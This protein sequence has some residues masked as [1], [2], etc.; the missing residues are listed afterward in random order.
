MVLAPGS[1]HRWP[2]PHAHRRPLANLKHV[3]T[4]LRLAEVQLGLVTLAQLLASGVSEA[5]VRRRVRSGRLVRILPGVFRLGGVPPSHHQRV[6][7]HL[8]WAGDRSAASHRCAAH[9]WGWDPFTSPT[10]VEITT[11]RY[12]RGRAGV[13]V[14]RGHLGPPDIGML[15]QIRMTSPARTLVDLAGVTSEEDLEI[16][17]DCSLVKARLS[18]ARIADVMDRVGTRGRSGTATLGRLLSYRV[19]GH[20]LGS[21]PLEVRFVRVIRRHRLPQPVSQHPVQLGD[22]RWVLDFAYPEHRVAIET[23][24]Y[25]WHASRERFE[26]DRTKGN[27]LVLAGWRLMRLTDRHLRNEGQVVRH[28][29]ELLGIT[30]LPGISVG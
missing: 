21:S 11:P 19:Q 23:D 9:L 18:T 25:R 7:A 12:L 1:M 8:L 26:A 29:Q 2:T 14:H 4:Y 10:D 27:G 6:L 20:A 13:V 5:G 16:A 17:L 24:G 15:R 3:E 22:R 30:E 28:L